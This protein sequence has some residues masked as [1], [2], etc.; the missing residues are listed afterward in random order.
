MTLDRRQFLKAAGIGMA[1]VPLLTSGCSPA[2]RPTSGDASVFNREA[3]AARNTTAPI[4]G[5]LVVAG[6]PVS[7]WVDHFGLPLHVHYGPRIRENAAAFINV[8]ARHY[9]KGEVR[10]AAKANAHPT[11]FKYVRESGAGIDVASD[12]EAQCALLAGI[13]T[14][15]MDVNGNTKSD[16]LIQLALAKGMVL[17]ADSPEEF[18]LIAGLARQAGTTPRVL[19][20]L[21]GF[22]IPLVTDAAAFTAGSWTKFGMNV[23]EVK[24][25]VSR[26]GAYPEIDFQGFHAHIGSQISTIEPYRKV[27]G[28]MIEASRTLIAAGH[29]CKMLNMGG[30]FPVNYVDK[31]QWNQILNR[32]RRGYLAAKKGDTSHLWAWDNNMVGFRDETTGQLHLDTWTGEGYYSEHP[33]ENM[34]EALLTSNVPVGG[35]SM[36]FAKA[37]REIGEPILVIEPGRSIPEDAGVTLTRVGHVKRVLNKHNLVAIEA[38]VVSFAEALAVTIPMNRWELATDVD[39]RDPSP[40]TGFIAGQLCFSGDMPSRYKIELPRRPARGDILL[41][42]DTGAYSPQF[43][44]A[45][46]N[47]FPRPSRVIVDDVGQIE[48][49][50]TRDTFDEVFS[51]NS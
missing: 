34:V 37:L 16:E 24:A 15:F 38:G 2:R 18:E 49:I 11:V 8:F 20:R 5:D 50:K 39:R 32:I 43:Y 28:R 36:P 10:F 45:S 30:G 44:A 17:I 25:F 22:D 48:F 26:L 7:W 1:S 27:A 31:K 6:Y 51:L 4:G 47:Y 13:D 46:T 14:K 33:K 9:P 41:T 12:N 42:H 40:F 19:M 35:K 23:H 21:S 3:A 29:P